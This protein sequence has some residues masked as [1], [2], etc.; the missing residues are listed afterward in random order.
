MRKPRRARA[1]AYFVTYLLLAAMAPPLCGSSA[2]AQATTGSIRGV[3]LDQTGAAV[4]GA[5]ISAKNEATGVSTAPL[6]S[7]G[8]GVYNLANLIPGKY[9]VTAEAPNFK[10][11]VYTSVDVR[12]GQDTTIDVAL[13]AGIATETVT[14]MAGTE[15]VINK[16]SAQ[17]SSSFDA[18]KV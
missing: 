4:A 16:E 8:E 13:Q 14:V 2:G 11:A 18:R 5:T 7:T 10:K 15:E 9:T 12:V 6:K 1:L 3:V 17:I